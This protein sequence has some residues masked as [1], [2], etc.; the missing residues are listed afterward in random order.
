MGRK[1]GNAQLKRLFGA[2]VISIVGAINIK[3]LTEYEI[4]MPIRSQ[5][6]R[7]VN[8]TAVMLYSSLLQ[9]FAWA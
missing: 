7:G 9:M 5:V 4:R 2:Y 6:E 8:R 1:D 3:L